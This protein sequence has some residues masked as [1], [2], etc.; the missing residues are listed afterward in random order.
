M[1]PVVV[2]A[3]SDRLVLFIGEVSGLPV[4]V[5]GSWRA[6][7]AYVARFATPAAAVDWLARVPG[8]PPRLRV[9]GLELDRDARSA[10]WE[11]GQVHLT[12]QEFDLLLALAEAPG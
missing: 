1:V 7:G 6:A 4:S 8:R 10:T 2:D 9:G 11:G 5:V 12:D 3:D